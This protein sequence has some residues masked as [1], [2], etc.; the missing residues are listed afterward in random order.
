M[1][2]NQESE[3]ISRKKSNRGA[4]YA[5][6]AVVVVVVIVL[7]LGFYLKWFNPATTKT[8]ATC[9]L[10]AATTLKGAGST[11]VN[12]LMQQWASAFLSATGTTVNYAAVGSG[13]GISQIQAK[14]VDF[15]ASDAPLSAAQAAANPATLMTFPESA[16]AVSIIYNIPGVPSLQLTGAVLAQIYLGQ[17][18]TWNNS[19][20][21]ALNPG[22][23]FPNSAIISVHRSDGSGTTYAFTQ[24]LSKDSTT[25]ASQV[26][27]ATAVNWPLAPGQQENAQKGSALLA[28]YVKANA[29]A[30]G[31][32]DLTYALTNS[33][34][35][36][37]IQNPSGNYILPNITNVASAVKDAGTGLPAGS[38]NWSGVSLINA[39]GASDYP[40]STF[41]YLLFYQELNIYGSAYNLVQ[42]ENL[43]DWL[44]WTV[45]QGQAYSATLY[46][47]PLPPSVIQVDNATVHS[48]T[49][50]GQKLP[51]CL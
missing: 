47:T 22:E 15:G 12:P 27:Y 41:T 40:I 18:Q 3:T 13:A 34:P 46:Y 16:G 21:T 33:I 20:I 5:V 51:I 7:G 48:V 49:Y 37:K 36:G 19:A 2:T 26:G 14:T 38:G 6:I 29:N 24:F 50:N 39:P 31:Y 23:T 30:I 10:P 17:I 45:A 25:W 44:N 1:S 9:K 4:V 8:S 32:V 43:V 11:F 35:Y 28:G 42:A